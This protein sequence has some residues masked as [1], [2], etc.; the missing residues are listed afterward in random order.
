MIELIKKK[1]F[2]SLI[3]I[4]VLYAANMSP[5]RLQT[6]TDISYAVQLKVN[7][8]RHVTRFAK[9]TQNPIIC[10]FD[11]VQMPVSTF[12]LPLKIQLLRGNEGLARQLETTKGAQLNDIEQ[13]I[14]LKGQQFVK[15][16][17]SIK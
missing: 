15:Q 12:R 7:K 5:T 14:L 1:E 2:I 10:W 3:Q 8:F 17:Q 4:E 6:S 9:E 11:C 16:I 13:E